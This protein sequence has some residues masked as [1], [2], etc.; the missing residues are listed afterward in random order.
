MRA[1]ASYTNHMAD[2]AA[3]C[4]RVE[5]FLER[6]PV[7]GP[8]AIRSRSQRI[9]RTVVNTV[10]VSD[11]LIRR[12][13]HK[14]ENILDFIFPTFALLFIFLHQQLSHRRLVLSIHFVP[15]GLSLDTRFVSRV[16]MHWCV[17]IKHMSEMAVVGKL[18]VR[19]ARRLWISS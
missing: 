19:T 14:D 2:W 5:H 17:V 12:V 16:D 4:L 1:C 6:D 13:T 18:L 15:C 10:S 8:F 3:I 7:G 11:Q 9:T